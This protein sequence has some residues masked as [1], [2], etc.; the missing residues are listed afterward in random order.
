[1]SH[2]KYS[3]TGKLVHG[4]RWAVV[5]AGG[6]GRR[7]RPFIEAWLGESRPKQ[8]CTFTG[9]RSML[10]MTLERAHRLV[11]PEHVVTVLGKGHREWLPESY[12]TIFGGMV[13]EQ[14]GDFGTA[15]GL[16][17]GLAYILEQDVDATVLVLPADQF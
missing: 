15:A 9:S 8:F 4:T 17:A 11:G 13:L 5:L 7:M 16:L 1:M 12:R 3:G 2:M 6:E 14:P 10:E